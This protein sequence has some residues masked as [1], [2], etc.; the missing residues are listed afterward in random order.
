MGHYFPG[1]LHNWQI[2]MRTGINIV[3]RQTPPHLYCSQQY[4]VTNLVTIPPS[5]VGASTVLLNSVFRSCVVLERQ[6]G[7]VQGLNSE[8]SFLKPCYKF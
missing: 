6:T 3:P 7:S 8:P 5:V 2:F 1:N 4:V